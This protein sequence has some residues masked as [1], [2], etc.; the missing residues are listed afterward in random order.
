MSRRFSSKSIYIVKIE[1]LRRGG[2]R[3]HAFIVLCLLAGVRSQG[4]RALT[5]VVSGLSFG[6]HIS[7]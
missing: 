2:A 5:W 7:S 1:H 3:L 6:Q 4:A